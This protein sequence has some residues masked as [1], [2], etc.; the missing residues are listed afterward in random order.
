MRIHDFAKRLSPYETWR[1]PFSSVWAR[2]Y[3][4]GLLGIERSHP[5]PQPVG[6]FQHGFADA[7]NTGGYHGKRQ[8]ASPPDEIREDLATLEIAVG[9][10]RLP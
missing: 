10:V 1:G 7:W 5:Y 9:E 4:R 8:A 6:S 2:G 3:V